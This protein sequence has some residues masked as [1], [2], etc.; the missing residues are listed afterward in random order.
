MGGFVCNSFNNAANNSEYMKSKM[1]DNNKLQNMRKL[2]WPNLRY[3]PQHLFEGTEKNHIKPLF[4]KPVPQP[5][6]RYYCP[7]KFSK[8]QILVLMTCVTITR[9]YKPKDLQHILTL[10]SMSKK[11]QFSAQELVQVHYH[12]TTLTPG[13][14]AGSSCLLEFTKHV[15]Y[16]TRLSLHMQC[17][18]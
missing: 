1:D 17:S 16:T 11:H 3:Y 14:Q 12:N 15:I 7:S 4:G 5:C 2:S 9:M 10:T 13:K 6:N 18:M 8:H